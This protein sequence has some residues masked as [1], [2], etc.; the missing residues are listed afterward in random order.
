VSTLQRHW[1]GALGRHYAKTIN[2][3]NATTRIQN[4]I[5]M[6]ISRG[7]LREKQRIQVLKTYVAM[8]ERRWKSH[9]WNRTLKRIFHLQFMIRK[10]KLIQRTYRGY[11]GRVRYH[12]FFMQRLRY[13]NAVKFQSLW[14]RY[15]AVI[16]MEQIRIHHTGQKSAVFIQTQFRAYIARARVRAMRL[17]YQSAIAIQYLCL[18][19]MAIKKTHRRR[20]IRA[21]IRIQRIIRGHL[22]R[23]RY[24]LMKQNKLDEHAAY[25]R[26]VAVI[27][28]VLF[29]YATRR[30][31]AEPVRIHKERRNYAAY[32][33]QRHFVA[34]MLG[35]KA[36]VRV[37]GIRE[38]NYRAD[39]ERRMAI[40]MQRLARGI[41]GRQLAMQQR[42][43]VERQRELANRIPYYYRMKNEYYLTQNMYH[44][45]FVVKIQCMVRQRIARNRIHRRI[46]DI[47]A[48]KIQ[49]EIR[50]F[51]DIKH[52][53][54]K[55]V[56]L[57]VEKRKM[58]ER[59][60]T[61]INVVMRCIRRY[62]AKKN[63]KAEMIKWF[64]GEIGVCIKL[65]KGLL[66]FR[67]MKREEVIMHKAST[68]IQKIVRG[69]QAKQYVRRNR[70]KLLR[71]KA[72][73]KME[74]RNQ[75]ALVIQ[76][77]VRVY[78]ARQRTQKQR[79]L[80]E[81]AER[82]R[83]EFE[84]LELSLEGLH[85]DFMKELLHIRA[86]R[87]ARALLAKTKFIQKVAEHKAALEKK[88]ETE[89]ADAARCIQALL[90]GV[91]GRRKFREDL[92]QL[93]KA[94]KARTYC[95]ECEQRVATRRCRQCKDKFCIPC[96]DR[97]HQKGNRKSHSWV[98]IKVDVR[99]V[100]AGKGSRGS[101]SFG[102]L[103][104][105]STQAVNPAQ[106]RAQ[107]RS[108][109]Q[110]FYDESARAKYWFNQVTGEASWTQ[111]N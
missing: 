41:A 86:Q 34:I 33:L 92:P 106:I 8:I 80:R 90:R 75:M 100:S 83:R 95:F 91:I 22:G 89:K 84:E 98:N 68:N 53:K 35:Q 51:L 42:E 46:L 71:V 104:A 97:I 40:R 10:A 47:A 27:A 43:I 110:E 44:R 4:Q 85:E 61:A 73:R 64:L 72:V 108:E 74:K 24:S 102:G 31:L 57:R 32:E 77:C 39:L 63:R 28:P 58:M 50:G 19:G 17:H 87:G 14:R 16:R 11:R 2:K 25:W 3:H 60:V 55:L 36:R 69:Q 6:F 56:E 107:K 101:V 12:V 99:A 37:N 105:S 21:A 38:A 78:R 30:R 1:R 62:E 70:K 103:D 13:R 88:A 48:A 67:A 66:N 7:V 93:K 18:R 76:C 54:M 26:A 23:I 81:E 96:Y 109:W 94:H 111:P 20:R 9:S 65:Q 29:G 59:T 45:P 82:E 49:R 15:K 79:Q 52:A 5:R